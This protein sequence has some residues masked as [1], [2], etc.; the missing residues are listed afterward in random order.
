MSSGLLTLHMGTLFGL[1]GP[2]GDTLKISNVSTFLALGIL[3]EGMI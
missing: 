1:S 2:D 3:T